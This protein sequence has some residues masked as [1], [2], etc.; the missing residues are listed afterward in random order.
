MRIRCVYHHQETIFDCELENVVIGRPKRGVSVNLDLT[1]DQG[2]SRPHARMQFADDQ[3]W[4]ED[5]DSSVGTQLGGQEIKGRGRQRLHVGSNIR[6]G[7][8]TLYVENLGIPSQDSLPTRQP[9]ENKLHDN[10][11]SDVDITQVLE[12]RE[13]VDLPWAGPV[14]ETASRRLTLLCELPLE[15]GAEGPLNPLLQGTLERLV[16]AIPAA[17][18]GAILV[19]DPATG[20]LLLKAHLPPGEPSVSMTA[21]NH[22]MTR[23]EG[24]IWR[25]SPDPSVS[26]RE[27][28]IASGIYAPLVCNAKSLGVICVDNVD[29]SRAFD[30]RDLQL[31][32]AAARHIALA[33]SHRA[34][35]EDLRRS[36]SLVERLLTNFSPK[37]RHKLLDKA[38]QGRLRLGGEKSEVTLLVSDIR[39]FTRL[40]A[41]M[42]AEDLMD[43]LNAY[44]SSLVEAIFRFDGTVDKFI[45][46]AILAVFGSPEPD[47]E[48]HFKAVRA[49]LAMQSMMEEVSKSRRARSQVTCEIGIGVHCGEVLHGF[50]GS[51]ERMEFTV[52]GDAVNCTARYCDGAAAGQILISPE[53]HQRVWQSVQAS[54]VN[55]STKHEGNWPAFRVLGCK[56]S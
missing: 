17:E 12:V 6:I 38:R 24:F 49:A 39:G 15:L 23:C 42:D 22:A 47:A 10:K 32:V 44:F 31:L 3:W 37:I 14:E 25:R 43:M 48:Q 27:N 5:L 55:L 9:A 56:G 29:S 19:Q 4:I 52:I 54:A 51:E 26:Q 8:T 20:R 41:D 45:G 33:V 40:S 28:R 16:A 50:I 18:R 13:R 30:S 53:V 1:P 7:E 46:D 11:L 35:Q 34:L 2:V 36:A 21:A